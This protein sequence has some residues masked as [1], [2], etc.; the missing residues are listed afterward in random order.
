MTQ[1]DLLTLLPLLV[2]AGWAVLLLLLDLWIP[3]DRKGFTAFLAA[4]GFM[5]T[6]GLV[7]WRS[8]PVVQ[9]FNHSVQVDGVSDFLSV[10]FLV[11]G[12]AGVTLGYEYLRRM[13]WERS[14]YYSLLLIAVSGML[15][16]SMANDLIVVFIALEVLSIPL[17]IL[18][19][20]VRHNQKSEESG[21]KYFLLGAF[22]S[23]FVLYG[24]ALVFGA[25]GQTTFPAILASISAHTANLPLMIVGATLLLVG[26]GFKAALAPFHMWS[27]DVYQGAPSAVTVF[28]SVGAKAAGF[29]ALVRVFIL[30]LPALSDT[31]LP[32]MWGLAALTMV[33]GNIAALN[34]K[35][36]KRLLAY[37]SI[38]QSGYILMAF[39]PFADPTAHQEALASLL[40]YLAAYALA[41]FAAWSVVITLEKADGTGLE[42][43]DYAGLA[44][45]FPGLAL[46]MLLAML[47]FAGVPLTVGFWGKFYLF[48]AALQGGQWGL[49]IIG[50]LTSVISAFYYLRLVVI[51]YMR[52]GAPMARRHWLTELTAFVSALGVV[53]LGFVPW[54][55]LQVTTHL[56]GGM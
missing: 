24:I 3:A 10:L 23:G 21:L 48:A 8:G 33:V 6:I 1:T 17:Y 31:L 7:I 34:Q 38:A 19:A 46:V 2:L 11:S 47:S 9:A 43:D 42:L 29:A 15:L 45:K 35:N 26:F 49:A 13:G 36:I 27:P 44:K 16:M 4:L 28:M 37:S 54:V 55:L 39:V 18:A 52:P 25:C 56:V 12:L 53:A 14:E 20:F 30:A 51:M 32:V 50:L 41:T 40:F 22:S 5:V